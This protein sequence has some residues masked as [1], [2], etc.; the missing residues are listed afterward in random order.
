MVRK[1]IINASLAGLLAASSPG[2]VYALGLGEMTLKSGLNQPF[3]AEIALYAVRETPLEAI[4]A[5]LAS[6]EAFARAGVERPLVLSH[7]RFH[8]VRRETGEIVVE[9]T[10]QRSIR[11][12][13]L[14]FLIAVTWP[15]GRLLREYTVLLD[16]PFFLASASRRMAEAP[17]EAA[18]VLPNRPSG[19]DTAVV[20]GPTQPND[21]LWPI[22]QRL[23][24]NSSVTPQQ[25]MLALQRVNPAAFLHNNINGLRVGQTLQA[26]SEKEVLKL[27]PEEAVQQVQQ[28]NQAWTNRRAQ[29]AV[30]ENQAPLA[31][32]DAQET[33]QDGGAEGKVSRQQALLPE[34]ASPEILAKQLSLALR[35]L[36]I[37]IRRKEDLRARL[38]IVEQQVQALQHRLSLEN[39]ERAALQ[40]S[41]ETVPDKQIAPPEKAKAAEP[42]PMVGVAPALKQVT[43][44]EHSS[45]VE[46]TPLQRVLGY[47]MAQ[48]NLFLLAGGGF[49]LLVLVIL[50][51][52]KRKTAGASAVSEVVLEAP[53]AA[54]EPTVI[55]PSQKVAAAES[56]DP[57]AFVPA[58][59]RVEV[60]TPSAASGPPDKAAEIIQEAEEKAP[61]V[62]SATALVALNPKPES[63]MDPPVRD[64]S[65]NQKGG[66]VTLEKEKIL[67]SSP[68]EERTADRQMPLGGKGNLPEIVAEFPP[69]DGK[70]KGLDFDLSDSFGEMLELAKESASDE[71]KAALFKDGEWLQDNLSEMEIKLD[72][73][74]AYIEMGNPEGAHPILEEVIAAGDQRQRNAGQDLLAKLAKPLSKR[75]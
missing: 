32:V 30:Q 34:R 12:P 24:P 74:R 17:G 72:L 11:A 5:E 46:T 22:A 47:F 61:L 53:G 40:G 52:R 18:R 28:Q 57:L 37:Q 68:I 38:Q 69:V 48:K 42:V 73:A 65:L 70:E 50:R 71:S 67:L 29:G 10:S 60:N 27:S 59:L 13:F 39:S 51:L 36:K 8:P 2:K 1:T 20:Y 75:V 55:G 9:V 6:P 15:R 33:L 23:R 66:A 31:G 43:P 54:L 41:L 16:P 49:L 63:P 64:L 44:P 4:H 58:A 19:K 62:D 14:D 26:P 21:S 7:L 25:M 56:I 45:V 3:Q 35:A